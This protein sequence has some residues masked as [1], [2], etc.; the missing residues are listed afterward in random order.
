MAFDHE[1]QNNSLDMP[2]R[3]G[4]LSLTSDG[5]SVSFSLGAT[6]RTVQ[7]AGMSI[8]GFSVTGAAADAIDYLAVDFHG[9]LSVK[10]K[11][12]LI[13]TGNLDKGHVIGTFTH[14]EYRPSYGFTA[15]PIII[16]ARSGYSRYSVSVNALN[17]EINSIFTSLYPIA[18]SGDPAAR[19]DYLRLK[20][21]ADRMYLLN[22][23]SGSNVDARR[24][25][26]L[27]AEIRA[28]V[29]EGG[30]SSFAARIN[31]SGLSSANLMDH[32]HEVQYTLNRGSGASVVSSTDLSS[33][34]WNLT[35]GALTG[36]FS[37]A[38]Y[39]AA[40]TTKS[41][42][43]SE[44]YSV[45][46]LD[47]STAEIHIDTFANGAQLNL[48]NSGANVISGTGGSDVIYGLTGNDTLSGWGGDDTLDGGLGTD[49]I[50]GG[51]GADTMIGGAGNDTFIV[52]NLGD[53][54]QEAVGGGID[55]IRT[56]VDF[57]QNHP[58]PAN[59]ENLVIL[60]GGDHPFGV[61]YGFGNELANKITGS[62]GVDYLEG[63]AGSDI[64]AGGNGSDGYFLHDNDKVVEAAGA[65]AGT[66]DFVISWLLKTTLAANV[67]GLFLAG[68]A[69]AATGNALNN[70][71]GGN[72]L[73]NVLN[74]GAG[75]DE[76]RGFGGADVL[77]GGSGADT[78]VYFTPDQGGDVIKDF[79]I[80]QGDKIAL[81]S[82][83]FAG[84]TQGG[85]LAGQFEAVASGGATSVSTRVFYDKSLDQL[86]Y[87]ADGNGSASAALI[88]SFSNR[89]LV[90]AASD[91]I[92]S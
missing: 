41:A 16:E 68:D 85:L 63:G 1:P 28:K 15:Q 18:L 89:S 24:A 8:G 5:G 53:L 56:Y 33:F 59:V 30:S 22:E 52:D 26:Q 38:G 73:A 90:L 55:T 77:T 32:W 21:I 87:D 70:K 46:A 31:A 61:A 19:A 13:P 6:G 37:V 58:L 69:I 42:L 91:I 43:G 45:S 25:D 64:L 79:S 17:S 3:L 20:Y 14:V 82:Y 10:I 57:G 71:I 39:T 92:V 78:F 50:D 36:A 81:W 62:S 49:W 60:E 84:L 88:A 80:L 54:V 7:S 83:N 35:A 65:E 48:G 29:A 27:A 44:F 23:Y 75:D 4:Y 47:L 76:I 9:V 74:G 12:G 72:A 2:D 67:E 86:Y 51:S 34:T 40:L 66:D 11:P